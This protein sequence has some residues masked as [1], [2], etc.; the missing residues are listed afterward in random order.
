MMRYVLNIH[1]LCAAH[2]EQTVKI[3]GINKWNGT[4]GTLEICNWSSLMF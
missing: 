3:N 2:G 1:E 4:K